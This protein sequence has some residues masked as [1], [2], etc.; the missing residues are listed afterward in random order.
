MDVDTDEPHDRRICFNCVDEEYLSSEVFRGGEVATCFYCGDE[1]RTVSIAELAAYISGAFERHYQRTATNPDGLEYA[2]M[3]DGDLGYEWERGG[4]G[5]AEAI[6]EAAGIP[7]DAA[8]D[9]REV[10]YEENYD[11]DTAAM[12]DEI[13][14]DEDVHCEPK[15]IDSEIWQREWAQFERSIKQES[16]FF[17]DTA[18]SIL[19]A[20]FCDIDKIRDKDGVGPIVVV[21]PELDLK[22]L[23]RARAFH[24]DAALER[25]LERPDLELAAPPPALARAGR[26]NASG[27]S[28]FYGA[29]HQEVALAEVRPPVGSRVALGRFDFIR[30]LNILDLN[31]LREI[32]KKGSI[33]DPH[34]ANELERVKFLQ[35]LSDRLSKPVLPDDE[36]I[37]YLVTQAV[38][39]FLENRLDFPLH[40]IAYPSVQS[41]SA[42]FNVA[43]FHRF[44]KCEV[45]KFPAKTEIEASFYSHHD[46]PFDAQYTVFERLTEDAEAQD[47]KDADDDIGWHG[48]IHSL[49]EELEEKIEPCL[50]LEG[51][52]VE[53]HDIQAVTVTT[54]KFEVKRHKIKGGMSP[55]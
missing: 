6:Q 46:D 23:Y 49:Y 15:E 55:F 32:V 50:R 35:T 42:G 10:L 34:Y 37:E 47:V 4:L 45:W 2:M 38:A 26:M 11:F 5:A 28:V 52:A 53:V 29:T 40:G 16:R 7:E 14:F 43:L 41:A 25:A 24:S 22:S 20:I 8:S 13:D 51:S 27:I 54:H 39:D 33:F 18:L 3:R 21:G 19:K 12:G 1:E 30:P 44:S 48:L 17:N 31:K 36:A 9:V